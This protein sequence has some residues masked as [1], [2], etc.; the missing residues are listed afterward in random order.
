MGI[1]KIGA[2]MF[3]DLDNQLIGSVGIE[4]EGVT[5]QKLEAAAHMAMMDVFSVEEAERIAYF[6]HE[7]HYLV[8]KH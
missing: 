1:E 6:K 3:Y 4:A 5:E 2:I 7:V 8:F